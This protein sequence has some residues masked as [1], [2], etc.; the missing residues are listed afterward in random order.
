MVIFVVSFHS[1]PLTYFRYRQDIVID[2]QIYIY[3]W[4]NYIV[5]FSLRLC[6]YVC[7]LYLL[8]LNSMFSPTVP[9]LRGLNN[10]D[11][12]IPEVVV[13][14]ALKWTHNDY[15]SCCCVVAFISTILVQ[16]AWALNAFLCVCVCVSVRESK[17][18]T[19]HL[20]V[21]LEILIQ[22]YNHWSIQVVP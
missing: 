2:K 18:N 1:D 17:R 8:S 16:W 15:Y 21:P 14:V 9:S 4:G 12:L 3:I 6:I 10:S 20:L 5:Y 22:P 19:S 7:H 13:T 11:S